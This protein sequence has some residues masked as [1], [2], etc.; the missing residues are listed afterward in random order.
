MILADAAPVPLPHSPLLIALTLVS[1][2]L[3]LLSSLLAKST[4]P[5]HV[6]G[7]ATLVLTAAAG[8]VAEWLKAGDDYDWRHGAGLAVWS[9]VFALIG[10]VMLWRDTEADRAARA[11]LW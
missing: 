11:K 10:R 1:L 2:F 3:P 9:L 8:L 6:V 7:L 5:A 4:W